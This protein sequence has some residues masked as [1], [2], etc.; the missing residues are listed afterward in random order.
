ME[1]LQ[2]EAEA[3]RPALP[4]VEWSLSNSFFMNEVINRHWRLNKSRHP[5]DEA[6]TPGSYDSTASNRSLRS[7]I[8]WHRAFLLLVCCNELMLEHTNKEKEVSPGTMDCNHFSFFFNSCWAL[9]ASIRLSGRLLKRKSDWRLSA[10]KKCSMAVSLSLDWLSANKMAA[11]AG[12]FNQEQEITANTSL[13]WSALWK[14][15]L[16]TLL[17]W[18][19][20]FPFWWAQKRIRVERKSLFQRKKTKLESPVNAFFLYDW[21]RESVPPE[22]SNFFVFLNP[23]SVISFYGRSFLN[24]WSIDGEPQ[25]SPT[26]PQPSICYQS[27]LR[28]APLTVIKEIESEDGLI[29]CITVDRAKSLCPSGRSDIALPSTVARNRFLWSLTGE[30]L[31]HHQGLK[32]LAHH[33]LIVSV[34]LSA[35]IAD[36]SQETIFF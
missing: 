33:R 1:E 13:R 4:T 21:N 26:G 15:L 25:L 11:A 22:N 19:L 8:H 18:A 16:L 24:D 29:P 7:T 34:R 28:N 27:L 35:L 9:K 2:L 32:P 14:S 30:R 5:E 6:I 31:S 17:F 12:R 20:L 23:S 36:G 10:E 3:Y